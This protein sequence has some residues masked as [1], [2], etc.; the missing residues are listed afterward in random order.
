MVYGS[1]MGILHHIAIRDNRVT[2]MNQ[3]FFGSETDE[4]VLDES[5]RGNSH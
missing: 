1:E 5:R 3:P 4:T 2:R